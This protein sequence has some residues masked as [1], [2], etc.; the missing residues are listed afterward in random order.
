MENPCNTCLISVC[1]TDLCEDK[2]LYTEEIL[3]IFYRFCNLH[4]YDEKS[5]R[6]ANIPKDIQ[7]EYD[8]L[9][10]ECEKN[11]REVKTITDRAC[12]IQLPENPCK[13]VHYGK[14]MQKVFSSSKLY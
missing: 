10:K 5:E 1:C 9:V 11:T 14:S 7:I 3:D 12:I 4:I 6:K 2:R 13:D 8:K